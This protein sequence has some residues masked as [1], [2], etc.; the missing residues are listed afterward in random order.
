MCGRFTLSLDPAQLREAFPW[1]FIPEDLKP[2]YNIAPSQPVAVVANTSSDKINFFSWGLVPSWAKDPSIGSHMINARAETI[3]EKPAFRSSYR[4][5]RCLILANGFYEWQ[6]DSNGKVPYYIY[7]RSR[8]PFAF[9]GLWDMW[10][11]PD[12][13]F[14]PSC[15][16][17]TTT[18]N[19]LILSI[20][21]RMPVIL[22]VSAYQ[23]WLDL[24]LQDTQKLDHLL[25]PYP[26]SEMTAHAVSK[27]VNAPQNDAPE[28]IQPVSNS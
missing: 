1:L 28:C 12:G 11:H 4:H 3:A 6:S 5:R 20:H 24:D 27:Y 10:T 8:K 2:R 25:A 21:N 17:I 18:P 15:T 14:L 7:M 23:T 9:A 16:I 13:S 22:P 26:A 19:E